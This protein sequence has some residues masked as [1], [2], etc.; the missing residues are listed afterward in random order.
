M[1]RRLAVAAA[2][3]VLLPGLVFAQ[4]ERKN[5]QVFEDVSRQVNRYT[6]FTVFDDVA[7]SVNHGEVTL[8]GKVTMPYK[9]EDIARLVA[10]VPGVTKV[11][12]DIKVLPV[13]PFDD[14]LRFQIA[15]RIYGNPGFWHYA[16]MPNPPIHILVENGKVTLTGVVNNNVERMLAQSI[17]T[18]SLAFSVKNELKTD[19]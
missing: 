13:S 2:I 14:D 1:F 11:S 16:A 12:N 3:V 9:A 10:R 4:T 19:A 6:R 17:A 18:S 15:R 7:A 5:L 8:T